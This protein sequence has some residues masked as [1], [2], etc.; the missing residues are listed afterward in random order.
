M[1]W[2]EE[3]NELCMRGHDIG[4]G[5]QELDIAPASFVNA[6]LVRE[7]TYFLV[8]DQSNTITEQ[9]RNSWPDLRL[10]KFTGI[11]DAVVNHHTGQ[12]DNGEG[13]TQQ[14][15]YQSRHVH[16]FRKLCVAEMYRKP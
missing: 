11:V 5:L 13:G 15:T 1:F 6:R 8:P 9:Y 7:Q 10:W 12:Q 14:S 16:L 3:R 2:R 4:V